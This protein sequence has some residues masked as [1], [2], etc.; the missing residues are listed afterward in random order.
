MGG[1]GRNMHKSKRARMDKMALGNKTIV[2][3]F[4]ERGGNVK[5]V[6]NNR[7]MNTLH[8]AVKEHVQSGSNLTTDHFYG[9]FNPAPKAVIYLTFA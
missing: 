6:I 1:K 3:G 5:K 4:L 2:A 7:S 9:Y 8:A